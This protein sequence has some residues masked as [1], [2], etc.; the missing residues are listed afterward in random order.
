M[1]KEGSLRI[2]LVEDQVL[3][4]QGVAALIE[5]TTPHRVVIQADNGADYERLCTQVPAP[6]IAIVGLYM[7][8]RDGFETIARIV[9]DQPHTIP[10]ACGVEVDPPTVRRALEVGSRGYL[11][12][13]CGAH[14]LRHALQELQHTGYYRTPLVQEHLD[15]MEAD[16]RGRDRVLDALSP[17]EREVLCLL[18]DH[19]ELSQKHIADHLGICRKTVEAHCRSLNTKLGVNTRTGLVLSAVRW[20]IV[21]V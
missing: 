1:A 9:T 20:G 10:L 4:R 6:D 8:V 18:C 12:K 2:A 3:F 11:A 16:K 14:E 7:P 17:R 5:S 15:A 21:K 19:G 13:N